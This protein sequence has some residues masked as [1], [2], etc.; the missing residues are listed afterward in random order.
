M[1][2]PA[3]PFCDLVGPTKAGSGF[4]CT[5]P[6]PVCSAI[7]TTIVAQQ[8]DS[9]PSAVARCA[10]AQPPRGPPPSPP[11]P[12]SARRLCPPMP[13]CIRCTAL[14]PVSFARH[15]SA[16]VR[17]K[18]IW[19]TLRGRAVHAGPGAALGPALPTTRCSPPDCATP[20]PL[21]C[22]GGTDTGCTCLTAAAACPKRLS[23]ILCQLRYL[24]PPRH[25]AQLPP[26]LLLQGSTKG[27]QPSRSQAGS[28]RSLGVNRRVHGQRRLRQ[29]RPHR[30]SL[31][32][33]RATASRVVPHE[34]QRMERTPRAEMEITQAAGSRSTDDHWYA[35]RLRLGKQSMWELTQHSP[36]C[37][38]PPP[39]QAG[40]PCQAAATA[41]GPPPAPPPA[42]PLVPAAAHAVP[43]AGPGLAPAAPPARPAAV[44]STRLAARHGHLQGRGH[45]A[46]QAV[47]RLHTPRQPG[48]AALWQQARQMDPNACNPRAAAL[49]I[50]RAQLAQAAGSPPVLRPL[51]RGPHASP[52]A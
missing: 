17:A 37:P 38:Q 15:K 35:G 24:A 9:A 22:R 48:S 31:Q 43:A 33:Q 7:T 46:G 29:Q 21:A 11:L 42:A 26:L 49:D 2:R 27:K 34:Q 1:H 4:G 18:M 13:A 30:P 52:L 50:R 28:Q 32:G 45:T 40:A 39:A 23:F 8:T 36:P 51:P 25:M 5:P 12:D 44:G 20:R 16:I 41:T 3:P 14:P 6:T 47:M 10:V 19:F